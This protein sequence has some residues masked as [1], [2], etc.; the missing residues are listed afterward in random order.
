MS[1]IAGFLNFDARPAAGEDLVAILDRMA[2]FRHA[3]ARF[4]WHVDVAAL[5]LLLKH[6]TPEDLLER[7]PLPDPSGRFLLIGDL[8]L[9]NRAELAHLFRLSAAEL[10]RT[11]DSG[12]ALLAWLRWRE[13]AA[14][15]LLGD[16]VFAV[17]DREAR[18]LYCARDHVGVRPLYFTQMPQRFAFASAIKGLFALEDVPRVIDEQGF[19]DFLVLLADDL[20]RTCWSGIQRLPAGHWMAISGA[21]RVHLERYWHPENVRELRLGSDDAYTEALKEAMTRAVVPRMRSLH[22]HGVLLSGGLDSSTVACYAADEA[23]ARGERLTAASSVLPDGWTGP[24]RDEWAWIKLVA[25]SRT[26]IDVIRVS[27]PGLGILDGLD[28]MLAINDQPFRDGF[29]YLT[30]ALFTAAL[31]RGARNILGGYGG[32]HVVSSHGAGFLAELARTGKLLTLIREL[33]ARRRP[34]R[35]MARYVLAQALLPNLPSGLQ[36]GLDRARKRQRTVWDDFPFLNRGY[37]ERH[38]VQERLE[39]RMLAPRPRSV[40]E[41]ELESL[42][43]RTRSDALEYFAHLGARLGI[44]HQCALLDKDLIQLS[45]AMPATV[46]VRSGLARGLIRRAGS[47]RVPAE[48]VARVDKQAFDPI[49]Q[50]RLRS[51]LCVVR[52]VIRETGQLLQWI[53]CSE[54]FATDRCA[55]DRQMLELNRMLLV[56]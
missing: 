13:R 18:A 15:H 32:D 7:Q 26:N 9:D 55:T 46:K 8:R 17:L 25:D 33:K 20:Q 21:G 10:A 48:I 6:H 30:R 36:R 14:E 23:L 44:R 27:A 45:L 43:L 19:A 16:F 38:A 31:D 12:L 4:G 42:A 52:S 35:S 34:G 49:Y 24:E 29:H 22:P 3:D 47:G 1:A 54:S 41:Q 39:R 11:P 51:S 28:E 53:D 50:S 40:R 37:L 2:A 56:L 5:G